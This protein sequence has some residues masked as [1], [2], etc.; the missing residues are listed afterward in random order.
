M[1]QDGLLPERLM[2][3]LSGFCRILAAVLTVIGIYE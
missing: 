3:K 2:A 1:I